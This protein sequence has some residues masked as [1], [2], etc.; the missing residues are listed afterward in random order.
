MTK[1]LI[2][3]ILYGFC[4]GYFGRDDYGDKRI[5]AIGADWV[6]ARHISEGDVTFYTGDLDKLEK[7]TERKD[8]EE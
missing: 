7:Y 6:V 2:G 3:Q 5:E 4:G 1:L 8:W